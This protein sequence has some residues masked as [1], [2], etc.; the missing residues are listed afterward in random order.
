MKQSYT[1]KFWINFETYGKKQSA[2]PFIKVFFCFF[3]VTEMND[4]IAGFVRTA[5]TAQGVLYGINILLVRLFPLLKNKGDMWSQDNRNETNSVA[6]YHPNCPPAVKELLSGNPNYLVTTK[7]LFF[8]FQEKKEL[9]T[10][11]KMWFSF[12]PF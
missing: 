5:K 3:L 1:L 2:A 12:P 11:P 9:T 4:R 8:I 6:Y 10:F 7:R